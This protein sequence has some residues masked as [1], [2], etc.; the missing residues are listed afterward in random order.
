MTA[1]RGAAPGEDY[2]RQ[3]YAT[4]PYVAHVN[5]PSNPV[6]NCGDPSIHVFAY[7]RSRRVSE[8][9]QTHRDGT[10]KRD[11]TD[12]FSKNTTLTS[13]L[14]QTRVFAKNWVVILCFVRASGAL[15]RIGNCSHFGDPPAEAHPTGNEGPRGVFKNGQKFAWWGGNVCRHRN[16]SRRIATGHALRL[17]LTA[18]GCG[19]QWTARTNVCH[20][21]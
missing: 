21:G 13:P 8:R 3:N 20:H 4:K 5:L 11:S 14:W 15:L 7:L 12:S 18:T 1:V 2:A 19:V 9:L 6:S 17:E 16:L 10:T